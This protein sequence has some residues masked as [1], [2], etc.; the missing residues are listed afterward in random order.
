MYLVHCIS[1][2]ELSRSPSCNLHTLYREVKWHSDIEH[3]SRL[4]L[5]VCHTYQDAAGQVIVI[6]HSCNIN[7]VTCFVTEDAVRI[8]NWFI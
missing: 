5:N 2:R 7:I 4:A 6:L 3:L 8:V 1:S